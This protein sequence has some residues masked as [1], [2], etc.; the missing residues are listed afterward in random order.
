V[1]KTADG[2]IGRCLRWR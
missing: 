2:I 1:D